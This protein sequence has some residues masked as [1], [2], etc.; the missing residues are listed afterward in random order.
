MVNAVVD[1]F[2]LRGRRRQRFYI[3][4]NYDTPREKAEAFVD[5]IRAI[6]TD[7]PITDKDDAYLHFNNLGE[8]G[9]GILLY[10]HLCA[11]DYATELR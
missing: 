9:L 5:G 2:G 8:S 11:S 3:Q 1:N 6:I 4:I 7:H 10:F